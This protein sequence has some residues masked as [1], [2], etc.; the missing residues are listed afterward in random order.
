[1]CSLASYFQANRTV[2]PLLVPRRRALPALQSSLHALSQFPL[3]VPKGVRSQFL[4]LQ[5]TFTC[6]STSC[7]WGYILQIL[8]FFFPSSVCD[9]HPCCRACISRPVPFRCCIVFLHPTTHKA[10]IH[11]TTNIWT[12][13][14]C[15]VSGLRLL[16]TFLYMRVGEH[17]CAFCLGKLL[18]GVTG[19]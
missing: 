2:P 18:S 11:S 17:M 19:V 3:A 14:R 10:F 6:F 8:L 15:R 5:T 4:T 16:R 12:V 9:T 13:S 7:K 1:M